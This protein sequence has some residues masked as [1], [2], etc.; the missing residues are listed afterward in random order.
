M[1]EPYTLQEETPCVG[2]IITYD[3]LV[4]KSQ[5]MKFM[6][7][8]TKWNWKKSPQYNKIMFTTLTIIH[9]CLDIT[10]VTKKKTKNYL[11]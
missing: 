7:D 11:Q 3:E 5:Y 2:K 10:T 8:N 6:Q 4:V 9:L 1:S